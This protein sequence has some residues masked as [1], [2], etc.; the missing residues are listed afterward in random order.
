MIDKSAPSSSTSLLIFLALAVVL[1]VDIAH[2]WVVVRLHISIPIDRHAIQ[3][4]GQKDPLLHG[5][6]AGVLGQLDVEEARVRLGQGLIRVL[7]V[8]HRLY[9]KPHSVPLK[10]LAVEG[11]SLLAP[12]KPDQLQSLLLAELFHHLPEVL[13]HW[14]LL[15]E[16]TCVLGVLLQQLHV[17]FGHTANHCLEL[18]P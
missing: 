14:R 11:Q 12:A 17:N 1:V 18:I 16:P 10:L 2:K 6:L 13:D 5:L 15:S 9:H 8:Q 7:L 4:D 3:I